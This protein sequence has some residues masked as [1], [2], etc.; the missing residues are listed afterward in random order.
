[1]AAEI[2]TNGSEQT[3]GSGATTNEE[4]WDSAEL[5]RRIAGFADDKLARDIVLLNVRDALQ[6]TDW[7]VIVSGRNRRHLAVIAETVAKELKLHGVHRLAGTPFKDD[8]WVVLDFGAVVLH[9]FSPVARE[10]YDLEN[11]WGDCERAE[12][13][14]A[15]QAESSDD[16]A[17]DAAPDATGDADYA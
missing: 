11:L 2:E 8:N 5:A 7:F 17:P 16:A 15:P 4:R 1:M 13:S 12:F 3:A 14:T 6:V 10:F 9:V